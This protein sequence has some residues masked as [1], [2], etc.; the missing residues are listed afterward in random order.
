MARPKKANTDEMATVKIENAFW[1]LLEEE[2]YS[3]ITVL[4]ISQESGTNRNSFYYHYRDI[5][6]LAYQAFRHIADTESSK[7]LLSVLL[8]A[9]QGNPA[10][11]NDLVDPSF[12]DTA[13]H[14]MLYAGSDST[15][16]K[17]MV[18]DLLKET[19]FETL[20]IKE[21]QLSEIEKLQIGFIFA[22][23]VATLGSKA[24]QENPATMPLL[25][26]TELGKTA[27]KTMKD[28]SETQNR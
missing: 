10:K 1:K 25:A 26:Q 12:L 16:L 4:R 23:L 15:F 2:S 5:E 7:M 18:S 3:E 28:I 6:D 24:V 11:K 8:S 17:D 9:F 14:V 20:A 19:W 22:G 27:I 21:D 13:K